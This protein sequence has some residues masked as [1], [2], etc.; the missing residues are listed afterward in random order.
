M[1]TVLHN[2]VRVNSI[3]C[4]LYLN[5]KCLNKKEENFHYKRKSSNFLDKY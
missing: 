4:K 3:V 1:V 5:K 2:C